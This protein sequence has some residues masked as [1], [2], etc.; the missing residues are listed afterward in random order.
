MPGMKKKGGKPRCVCVCKAAIWGDDTFK[1]LDLHMNKN[2]LCSKTCVID[3]IE[4]I[5]KKKNYS[6]IQ[7]DFFIMTGNSS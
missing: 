6:E 2:R 1:S 7:Y 4:K 5:P 3:N